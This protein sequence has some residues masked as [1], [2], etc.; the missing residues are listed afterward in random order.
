MCLVCVARSLCFSSFHLSH[1]QLSLRC[2]VID[3]RCDGLHMLIHTH[4]FHPKLP[5]HRI[6][7][8]ITN[9]VFFSHS[10]LRPTGGAADFILPSTYSFYVAVRTSVLFL[11]C[12][13][14][15]FF[16]SAFERGIEDPG[17]SLGGFSLPGAS[18]TALG[19][20]ALRLTGQ[21]CASGSV[22]LV[23]NLNE[24]VLCHSRT[25]AL[26]TIA[27]RRPHHPNRAIAPSMAS[28]FMS[29]L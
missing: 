4:R 19:P 15:L 11:F 25:P 21:S 24:E 14:S 7:N 29:F 13:V 2:Q 12:F 20:A 3:H 18:A 8:V 22:L 16:R 28:V 26:R 1:P 27:R 23:S 5:H 6:L 10:L 9:S 17:M